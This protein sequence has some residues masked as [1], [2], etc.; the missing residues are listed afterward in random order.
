M[1]FCL[2]K[3]YIINFL[4]YYVMEK[5]IE[6][7]KNGERLTDEEQLQML[8]M[9]KRFEFLKMFLSA[10]NWLCKA[11][12]LKLFDLPDKEKLLK[13]YIRQYALCDMAEVK[14]LD[15]PERSEFLK[16][17]LGVG[18]NLCEKAQLKMV[19]LP[20]R[21]KLLGIYLL[22][23]N[24]LCDE[25][26]LKLFDM[27]ERVELFKLYVQ[28]N[29][30]CDWAELKMLDM[31]ER[32]EFLGRYLGLGYRLCDKAQKRARELRLM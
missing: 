4:I 25:A 6:K 11:A 18:Y 12:Q 28:E 29:Y 21:V 27:P 10:R 22:P 32:N 31:P 30:L 23:K 2:M 13:R 17:Y 26:E 16:M 20:E 8:E 14:M 3:K 9:P 7:I 1:V 15:M 24:R 19:G 5:I